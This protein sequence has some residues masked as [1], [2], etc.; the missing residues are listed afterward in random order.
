MKARREALLGGEPTDERA[1]NPQLLRWPIVTLLLSGLALVVLSQSVYAHTRPEVPLLVYL[2]FA[3]GLAAFLLAGHSA[4]QQDTRFWDNGP[5]R[6]VTAFLELHPT[7]LLMLLSAPLFAYLARQAAGDGVQALAPF[8]AVGAW[9]L[10]IV[11]AVLGSM[12]REWQAYAHP[13]R[14][15]LLLT[16]ALLVIAFLLRGLFLD[17]IPTTLSGDEASSGLFAAQFRNGEVNNVLGLGWFSFPSFYFAV[18]STGI[19]LLGQTGAALRITSALAGALTVFALYWLGRTLYGRLVGLLA[20]LYLLAS[21]FHIHFSRIGLQN[22]WDGLFLT[23]VWGGIWHGW[24]SGRRN[25]FVLA[26]LVL[27]L[28]PYFYVSSRVLPLLLLVWAGVALLADRAHFR[29]RFPDLLLAAFVALIVVLPLGLLFLQH[30]AEFGAPMNRVSVFNGWLDQEVVRT[31]RSASAIILDEMRLTA[32]GFAHEPLRHWYNPGAPLLLP[33]AGGLFVAGIVWLAYAFD[34]RSL[35]LLLPL[36]AQVVMGGLSQ[37]AP[38]SQRFVLVMPVVAL[39]LALPLGKLVEWVEPYWPRQRRLLAALALL[40]MVLI[41]AGDLNYYF[42]DVYDEYVL[43]GA[44]TETAHVM[45]HYLQEQEDGSQDVYFFGWP[46]MGYYSIST[47]PYL[48]PQMQ[49]H[50][51]NQPLIE[52]PGWNLSGPSIFIFLPERQNELQHIQ[53]SFPQGKYREVS[54][55]SDT[56]G[57]PL[58]YAY[59]V[60]GP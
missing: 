39:I 37:D 48:A 35:L 15:E 3:L 55:L 20:A 1:A 12:K 4:V 5:L 27:G 42:R 60:D 17:Q 14:R 22:I 24:K 18:Q 28:A 19:W 51:I 11:A 58:F 31:G 53:A 47:V 57:P 34:L 9:L 21:H 30:P 43:G 45:A 54:S 38:A 59:E 49:G 44:N 41:V 6:A 8:A 52:P 7:Q 13:G 33:A 10:A 25:S 50:D 56:N 40:L 32:L 36:L 46:R 29:Q 26:G 16:L 2:I 23:V